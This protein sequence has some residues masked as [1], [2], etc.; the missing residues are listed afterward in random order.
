VFLARLRAHF[1]TDP[2]ALPIITEQFEPSEQP[3]LQAALDAWLRPSERSFEAL[4]VTSQQ[5]RY[6]GLGL[7]DMLPADSSGWAPGCSSAT[8]TAA[9]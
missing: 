9:T 7:A 3:N 1:G 5:K 6:Q 4:G 2:V 8:S